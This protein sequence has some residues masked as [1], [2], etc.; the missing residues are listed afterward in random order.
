MTRSADC[1]KPTALGVKDVYV[2]LYLTDHENKYIASNGAWRFVFQVCLA[3]PRRHIAPS[4]DL[5]MLHSRIT[6][7][8]QTRMPTY[9]HVDTYVETLSF[10][11]S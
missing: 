5:E 3:T 10:F 4:D 2:N 1:S 8:I 9:I 7:P 11:K 6:R